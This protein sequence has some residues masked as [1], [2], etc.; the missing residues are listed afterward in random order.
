M[1]DIRKLRYFITVVELGSFTKAAAVLSVAQPALTRQIQQLE[2]EL[3][4]ELL[5]REGRRIR[6]T[7]AGDALLRHARMI[8]RDFER[9]REDI[10]ARKGQ[11]RGRVVFGIPPTLADTLVPLL[12]EATRDKL[13]LVTLKIIEG[14]T[15]VLIDWVRSGEADLAILSLAQGDDAESAAAV[16]L[17]VVA[18]EDM[19]VVEKAREPP[20]PPLYEREALSSKPIVVSQMLANIVRRQLGAVDFPLNVVTEIDSV[21]AIKTMVLRGQAATILP[22]SMLRTE[23]HS[24]D[25][26]GSAITASPVQRKLVLAQPSHRHIT[27]ATESVRCLVKELIEQM[28]AVGFFSLV[29]TS[30]HQRRCT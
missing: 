27:Q 24:G 22:V 14:L 20:P 18:S 15:P 16:S 2:K 26:I 28:S 10:Q 1:I 7:E 30:G 8:E 5:L 23:L 29:A 19:V 6:R 4:L 25:V 21:Q 9:L 17:E 12:V 13:P 3:G 11:P